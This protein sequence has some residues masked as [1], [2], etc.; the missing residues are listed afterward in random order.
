MVEPLIG[1]AIFDRLL[2]VLG[3]IREDTR[4]AN[5]RKDA[6]LAAVYQ[7]LVAT[8]LYLTSR[9]G[10]GKR[11]ISRE[12]DIAELWHEASIPLRHINQEFAMIAF[13]K[14]GY[15]TDPDIW[16]DEEIEAKGIKIEQVTEATRKLL[17]GSTS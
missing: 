3:W 13:E 16:T 8:R 1:L 14:G 15:W 4:I 7:A 9:K 10:D 17:Q 2:A 6:A 12:H 11:N 5:E